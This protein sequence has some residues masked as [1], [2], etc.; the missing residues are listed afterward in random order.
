MNPPEDLQSSGTADLAALA[1]KSAVLRRAVKLASWAGDGTR[2]LTSKGVLRKQDVPA[3]VSVIGV[4]APQAVRSA[5]DLPELH[6]AW[7]AAIGMGLLMVEGGK[8]SGGPALKNWPPDDDARLLAV[9]L[10]GF[11]AV[12]AGLSGGERDLGKSFLVVVLAL[13]KVLQDQDAPAGR[14]LL[15]DVFEEADE[16]CDEY[17]LDIDVYGALSGL[18]SQGVPKIEGLTALLADFGMIVRAMPAASKAPLVTPLGEWVTSRLAEAF[19]APLGA[20]LTVEE[21]VA[22]AANFS[23][24]ERDTLAESWLNARDPADAVRE[25]LSAV[26]DMPSHLRTVALELAEMTGEDGWPAWREIAG[27]GAR[28][29]TA[30]HARVFLFSMGQ[31]PEP[32]RADWQWV[33]TEAAVVALYEAGPDEALCCIW[34]TIDGDDDIAKRL[35]EVRASGHPEAEHVASSVE[36]FAASGAPLSIRRGVQLKIA[37][38]YMKPPVWRGVQLPLTA[39]LGDLHAAIQVLFGWDGDHLHAF[40]AGGVHFS[41]SFYELEETEDEEEARLRDVFPPGGPKITY[42]YDFGA[43]WVHEITRQKVIT[44]EPG[45]DYPLCVAFGG[46]S[47]VEYPSEDEPEEPEPFDLAAVN[48]A[49]AGILRS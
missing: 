27:D 43:D 1:A 44:L 5:A 15:R 25:I 18:S 12:S 47:P 26:E 48:T 29:C 37:L 19:P 6:V 34:D 2:R 33:G 13:L 28:P 46:D 24:A 4:K 9:W 21:L 22:E 36:A 49:L 38:K 20:E 42:V 16:I 41:D 7:C 30:R 3:A 14:G 35:A 17:D 45:Q 8:A 11:F 23:A 39:T 10:K 31:G 32:A 40:H